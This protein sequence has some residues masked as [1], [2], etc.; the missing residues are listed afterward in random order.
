MMIT[1]SLIPVQKIEQRILLIRD[2]KVIIDTDLA[3]FYGVT[4]KRLNEQ[5]KRNIQR[6]PEDFMFQLTQSEKSEVV[7]KC[8]HLA[9]LKYSQFLP[10]VFTEH[11]AIM[12]ASVINSPRA[13]HFSV[14]I[15]R[16][17]IKLRQSLARDK[18]LA[19]RMDELEKH[20]TDHDKQIYYLVQGMKE[21]INPESPPNKRRIGFSQNQQ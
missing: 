9:K 21:L 3:E 19:H 18:K 17:F 11:G 12:A 14:F 1:K 20:L 2:E 10:Y 5:V 7:A 8:D 13:I 6:F 16:A 4:T 15:V